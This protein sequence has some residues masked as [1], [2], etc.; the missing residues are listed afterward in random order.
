VKN[1]L[2]SVEELSKC[3]EEREKELKE[4]KDKGIKIVGV[5][6]EGYVQDEIVHALGA[7]PQHFI[8]GGEHEAIDDSLKY[9]PSTNSTFYR[10]QLSYI[11]S[12]KE[13]VYSLADA[14]IAEAGDWNAENVL[15]YT[16]FYKKIMGGED[17][18]DKWLGIPSDPFKNHSEALEYYVTR[19][20]E[21][22]EWLAPLTGNTL[23]EEKLREYTVLYNEMRDLL[24]KISDLRKSPSPPI[25]GLDFITLNHYSYYC[26][27]HRYVNSLK[28]IYDEL[29][30]AEG[31]SPED[32]PRIAI[33]GCPIALGDY[34]L[35]KLVEDLGAVIPIEQYQCSL[36]HYQR[37][38]AVN[39]DPIENL[40]KRYLMITPSPTK[41]P[42][43]PQFDAWDKY[44]EDFKVD[45]VIWYQ[46]MYESTYDYQWVAFR[47]RMSERGMPTM[48]IDSEYDMEERI[49]SVRTRLETFIEMIK[50]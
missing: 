46:L 23:S 38:T 17:I 19:T 8:K 28:S 31:M 14:Y 7:V 15:M 50:K 49:E 1:M 30:G 27:P 13:P 40:C 44:I 34:Q 47:K 5:I 48:I 16:H 39:G 36:R 43:G 3:V 2:E 45:A 24:L 42:W 26:E 22:I 11:L 12:G 33:F 32:A 4:L 35:P 20:K 18:Q 25:S 21:M 6:G 37:K 10:A 41:Y 29:K 9:C